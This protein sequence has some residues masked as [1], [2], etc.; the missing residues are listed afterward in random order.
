MPGLFEA[1]QVKQIVL[2]VW[3]FPAVIVTTARK[4][5]AVVINICIEVTNVFTAWQVCSYL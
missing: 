4:V 1:L 2:S 5:A 3:V